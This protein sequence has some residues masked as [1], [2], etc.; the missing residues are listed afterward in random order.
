[1]RMHKSSPGGRKGRTGR[2]RQ[3]DVKMAYL[4]RD[5]FPS[6]S[7]SDKFS[8]NLCKSVVDSQAEL[9]YLRFST[10]YPGEHAGA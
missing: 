5:K 4:F 7:T 9:L 1:M 6:N 3:F 2:S 8:L 10:A